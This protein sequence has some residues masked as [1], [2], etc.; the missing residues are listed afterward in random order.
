VKKAHYWVLRGGLS[1]GLD[2]KDFICRVCGVIKHWKQSSINCDEIQRIN[3]THDWAA[4]EVFDYWICKRCQ[5]KSA[6]IEE[7]PCSC[8]SGAPA[9]TCEEMVMKRALR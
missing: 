8:S 6:I 5:L 7:L 1:L 2:D 4:D 3:A 9:I